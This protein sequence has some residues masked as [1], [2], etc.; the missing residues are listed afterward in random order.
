MH[1]LPQKVFIDG[2]NEVMGEEFFGEYY[3]HWSLIDKRPMLNKYHPDIV[4]LP[5]QNDFLWVHF[6]NQDTSWRLAYVDELSAVY[7]RNG[8]APSV[9][10][11][12]SMSYTHNVQPIPDALIDSVLRRPDPSGSVPLSIREQYFP[13][14]E[15]GLSTFCYY[16]D[17]FDAAI[18][19]GLDGLRRSTV[20]CPEMY[21]NLGNYFW[22]KKDYSHAA[23]CYE[24]MLRTNEEPLAGSRLAQIR[25]SF[26]PHPTMQ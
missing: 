20:P 21:Y 10:R 23:Y 18:Q 8:Y 12:D 1:A 3:T 6:F 24:R 13:Q 2:R 11:L 4:I 5:Y 17:R 26:S 14:R 25:A 19:I 16:D 7:L 22:E 9:P 15:I